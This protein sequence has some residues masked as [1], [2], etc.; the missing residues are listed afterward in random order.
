MKKIEVAFKGNEY[1]E[2]PNEMI[3]IGSLDDIRKLRDLH[4]Q[5]LPIKKNIWSVNSNIQ[6]FDIPEDCDWRYDTHHVIMYIGNDNDNITVYQYIQGKYDASDQI[7]SN[8]IFLNE[9][10]SYLLKELVQA[11]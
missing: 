5:L 4:A 3:L 8:A 1:S 11:S 7:E 10:E 6:L 2:A 9:L